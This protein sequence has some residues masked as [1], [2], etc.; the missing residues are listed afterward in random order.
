MKKRNIILGIVLILLVLIIILSIFIYKNY[1]GI[2]FKLEYESLN[3]T[4]R[5]EDGEKYNNVSISINNQ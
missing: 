2:K 4:I 3:N 1:D 5:E